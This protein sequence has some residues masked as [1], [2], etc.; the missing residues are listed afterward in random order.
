MAGIAEFPFDAVGERSIAG[1]M[2]AL[3]TACG[4]TV[5]DESDVILAI[6]AGAPDAAAR[7][8]VEARPGLRAMTNTD[9]LGRLQQTGFSYFQ[10]ISAVLGTVTFTFALL[11]IGVLLTVSVNQRLG[12]I[13][14]LRAIGCT[15]ARVV[16]GVLAESAV[17]VGSGGLVSLP[18]GAA[19]ATGLDRLLTGMPG[20]PA[21][22]H[23]FVFDPAAL[24]WH[25]LLLLATAVG[26]AAYPMVIVARLPI[27]TTLRN[28]VGS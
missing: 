1:P 21:A 17:M 5:H 27:A 15:R 16:A 10:Q 9:V 13:A 26:A 23:F 8:M 11:L 4:G 28:E 3:D 25:G 19:L 22:M 20:L 14:A 12:E 24:A 18:L 2:A 7:A 6:S